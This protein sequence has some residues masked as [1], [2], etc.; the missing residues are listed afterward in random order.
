VGVAGLLAGHHA[1]AEA[2][3]GVVG[4]ALQPPVVEGQHLAL[5]P[6]QEQ[7]PVV[8]AVQGRLQAGERDLGGRF[9]GVE[10]GGGGG[11]RIHAQ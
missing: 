10:D 2:L 3:G 4:R 8:G 9:G 5:R 6:F 11:Q 7:L 1:Q